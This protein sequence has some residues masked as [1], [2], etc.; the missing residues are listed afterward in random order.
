MK[1]IREAAVC[2]R[3]REEQAQRPQVE[4][5]TVCGGKSKASV[6]GDG[7]RGEGR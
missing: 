3:P 5:S 7:Q 4:T 6:A 1:D 2:C